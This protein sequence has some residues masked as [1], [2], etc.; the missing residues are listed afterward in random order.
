MVYA[1]MSAD[2]IVSNLAGGRSA[3]VIFFESLD[4]DLKIADL[5]NVNT[6]KHVTPHL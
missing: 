4:A 5:I 3:S 2:A 6:R 1:F